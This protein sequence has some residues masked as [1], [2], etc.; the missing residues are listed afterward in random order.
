M[1]HTN[2][3]PMTDSSSANSGCTNHLGTCIIESPE[4]I[5]TFDEHLKNPVLTPEQRG[6]SRDAIDLHRR[7]VV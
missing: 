6:F 4:D 5:H 1:H 7:G 2:D 3:T